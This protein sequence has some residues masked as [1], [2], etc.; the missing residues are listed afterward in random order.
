M[1][2]YTNNMKMNDAS[3]EQRVNYGGNNLKTLKLSFEASLRNLRTTYVD[4]FY[5]HYWDLH[6]SVEEIMDGL[7]NLVVEGKVLYL[8][9]MGTPCY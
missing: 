1:Q 8:V 3:V 2:Q 6:T 9:R 5:L 7:H 4:I